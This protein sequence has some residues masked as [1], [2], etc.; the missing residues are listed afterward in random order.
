MDSNEFYQLSTAFIYKKIAI[1]TDTDSLAKTL[2]DF[3]FLRAKLHDTLIDN[4]RINKMK[5][6][7]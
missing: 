5:S 7:Y 4:N 2:M 1:E 3:K 6:Y